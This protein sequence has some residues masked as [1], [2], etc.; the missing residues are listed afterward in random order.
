MK[1]RVLILCALLST[2]CV[3][4]EYND[5]EL[6]KFAEANCFFWYFKKNNFKLDD[7]RGITGG[8]VEMGHLSA[9]KYQQAAL[10]VKDYKPSLKFKNN[11]DVDLGKCFYMKSDKAFLEKLSS[12]ENGT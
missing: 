1:L 4:Q 11:I 3:S 10:A 8:M 9:E 12:I 7:I 2:S 5:S 6:V